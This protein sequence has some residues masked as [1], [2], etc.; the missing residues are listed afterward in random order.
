MIVVTF[1]GS[2]YA[3]DSGSAIALWVVTGVCLIAYIAQQYFLILTTKEDRIFP[4]H[5]L[6]SRAMV[7]LFTATAG[8]G[9]AYYNTLYYLPLF[10]QFTRGDSATRAAVRLLPMICLYIFFVLLSGATL[11][12]VG[13]YNL[14]YILSGVLLTIGCSLAFTINV[15]TS[16][17]SIYGYEILI[18]AGAGLILQNG[19]AI[20]TAKAP[21]HDESNALGFMN[22]AQTGT[23]AFGLSIAG[24]LFQNLG[25][26]SLRSGLA[27][28]NLPEDYMRSAL[29]GRIS[30][31]FESADDEIIRIAVGAAAETIR[32]LFG[33]GIAGGAVVLV[34][35]LLM[36]FEMLDLAIKEEAENSREDRASEK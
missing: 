33:M 2:T 21:K 4:A 13:R 14:Y 15:N 23:M 11:P 32:R 34:S 18:A 12:M 6:K 20:A 9:T 29:A 25:F 24:C 1:S 27:P 36:P 28:Y 8:A 17:A 19:F 10:F 7:M 26:A 16:A 22:V 35:G 31:I 3:W 5:L 30:P